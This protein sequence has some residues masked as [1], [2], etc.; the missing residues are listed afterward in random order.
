MLENFI[1][2]IR[3]NMQK[4]LFPL[5]LLLLVIGCVSGQTETPCG[6][7]MGQLKLPNGKLR[8]VYCIEKQ[9]D[10]LT[11]VL[12]SPDQ[13]ARDIP[14]QRLYFRN[15][16]IRLKSESIGAQF[17]GHYDSTCNCFIGKFVQNGS[18]PLRL[19]RIAERITWKRPQQ[20]QPPFPYTEESIIFKSADGKTELRGSLCLPEGEGPFPA[21]VMVS[22]SGWQDRNE[23]LLGHQPFRVISD[24]LARHGIASLRYDDRYGKGTTFDF[25]QDAE[26]GLLLLSQDARFDS[27]RIGVL[28]HSEGGTIAFLLASRCR[29]VKFIV[30]L[31]GAP[32][33]EE[34]LL[35]QIEALGRADGLS[36]EVL[37]LSV[38][39]SKETYGILRKEKNDALAMDKIERL[40]GQY[41]NRHSQ[42]LLDSAGIRTDRLRAQSTELCG[43]WFRY[44]LSLNGERIVRR[45]RCPLLII[46]GGRDL[47]VSP[48]TMERI[49]LLKQ[50]HP[51]SEFALFPDLNHL[52]QHCKTGALS[53]YGEIEE[54]TAAEVLDHIVRFVRKF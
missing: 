11:A 34:S 1:F 42:E 3:R 44:A 47:Q 29:K 22:G 9:N 49:R 8:I 37:R 18:F 26:G 17:K 39:F 12:D 52:L 30:S 33:I 21:V 40:C 50:P 32:F 16:S 46:Q 51:L 36:E 48:A 24:Y 45:T 7:W 4:H 6:I 20:P 25:S 2:G 53:E 13:Y 14:V 41:A 27:D 54:T 43:P 19:E 38:E 23:S 15:D 28:G 5:L 10:S 35:Y 31:A